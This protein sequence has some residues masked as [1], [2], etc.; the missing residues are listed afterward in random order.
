M[1]VAFELVA[2]LALVVVNGFFALAE[3][4]VV[5]SRKARLQQRADEGDAGAAAALDLAE[6][7]D[8]FLSTVQIGITLVGVLAGA[9]GGAT[10]A[11]EMSP[12]FRQIP[13]LAPYAETISVGLVVVGVTYLSLVLGELAPK[14]LALNN[15]EKFAAGIAPLMG[16]LA[17]IV[18]PVAHFLSLSADGVLRILGV[19]VTSSPPVT[20]QEIVIMVE[21]GA[22]V[23]VF[24][25]LEE[26]MVDHVFRLAERKV[27]AL[28]TP[29]TEIVWMEPGDSQQEIQE[30]IAS[31]GHSRFPVARD[32][33]DHVLGV[34]L[35][36]DL[37]CQS[38]SQE[39][40]DLES[41][42]RPVPFV[43]ETISALE[44]IKLFEEQQTQIAL[45]L[46]EYGGLQ[47]LVTSADL[48]LAIVGE[49][50]EIRGVEEAGSVQR[51]DGSWLLDGLLPLDEFQD[52]FGL[53]EQEIAGME[54]LGGL[55]MT[56]L[57]HVP[58]TGETVEWSGLRFEVMD[59][60]GHR[61]DKVLVSQDPSR[62]PGP[63]DA[64]P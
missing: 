58:S 51:A 56:L 32:S 63:P 25:P 53:E 38:L 10:L 49:A 42:L 6:D 39:P 19:R 3:M 29:R 57:E 7:P 20:R 45:V 55:V 12:L 8:D 52:L 26:E 36:K 47:G 24:E 41:A 59:M 44:L 27:S 15:A 18:S 22:G 54:T 28:L 62:S 35:A 60:D 61:V 33:L 64:E 11:G 16:R 40:I 34:V 37:L 14:R 1:S 2:I 48:L 9:F 23:G 4:A 30:R 13:F 50:S 17:R 5:S 43:P 21:E 46:D 31:S